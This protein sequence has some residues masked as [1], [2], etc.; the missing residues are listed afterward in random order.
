M[1]TQQGLI[2]SAVRYLNSWGCLWSILLGSILSFNWNKSLPPPLVSS[3]GPLHVVSP[4]PHLC[5][6]VCSGKTLYLFQ[7]RLSIPLSCYDCILRCSVLNS[8]FFECRNTRTVYSPGEVSCKCS[9]AFL[10]GL[11]ILAS[12]A[13]SGFA[14]L[15]V[16]LRCVVRSYWLNRKQS[17][18]L[19]IFLLLFPKYMTLH[20]ALLNFFLVLALRIVY[21]FLWYSNSLY[22]HGFWLCHQQISL[23]CTDFVSRSLSVLVL[24]I[25]QGW[26]L[27]NITDSCLAS[28]YFK[29]SARFL[30]TCLLSTLSH[31]YGNLCL[32]QNY[33]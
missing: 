31:N 14:F 32:F 13:I 7:D 1:A 15:V 17:F 27:R 19:M 3:V 30:V 11:E 23:P 25:L 2:V 16:L 12:S 21:Y 5:L 24:K 10:S 22:W 8:S 9:N 4:Q 33:E 26:Y 28:N 18:Q 29:F 6:E 20:T